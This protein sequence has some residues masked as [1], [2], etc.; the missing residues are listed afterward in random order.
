[1]F[2]GIFNNPAATDGSRGLGGDG[3]NTG[4]AAAAATATA[5]ATGTSRGLSDGRFSLFELWGIL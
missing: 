2:R 5:T 1:M 4:M 3:F